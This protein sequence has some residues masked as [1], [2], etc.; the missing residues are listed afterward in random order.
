[1]RVGLD[2][3]DEAEPARVAARG[4]PRQQQARQAVETLAEPT[5]VAAAGLAEL[6]QLGELAQPEGRPKG[7]GLPVVADVGGD[8]LV[9][10]AVRQRPELVVKA[11]EA[12]VVLAGLAPAVPAPVA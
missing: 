1:R 9:V 11:L 3:D 4:R 6:R 5:P 12:G 10:V 2:G 7:G 8:V